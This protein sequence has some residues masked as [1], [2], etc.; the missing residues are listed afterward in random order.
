MTR[1]LGGGIQPS[2]RDAEPRSNG[3]EATPQVPRL[4]PLAQQPKGALAPGDV[5]Q[6]HA[7]QVVGELCLVR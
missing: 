1:G 7:P 2:V 6:G 3:G 5:R 4:Q